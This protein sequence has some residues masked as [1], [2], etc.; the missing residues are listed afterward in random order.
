MHIRSD[1]LYRAKEVEVWPEFK[2]RKEEIGGLFTRTIATRDPVKWDD[3]IEI[4]TKVVVLGQGLKKGL[5]S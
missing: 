3:L 4:I 2:Q 1:Y 5:L